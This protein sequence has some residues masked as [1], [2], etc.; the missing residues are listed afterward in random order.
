MNPKT[1]EDTP[2]YLKEMVVNLSQYEILPEHIEFIP[3]TTAKPPIK[4]IAS[5]PI[6]E[7]DYSFC[8]KCNTSPNGRYHT[9]QLTIELYEG[10]QDYQLASVFADMFGDGTPSI[11]KRKE[12]NVPL[13]AHF[14]QVFEEAK[15]NDMFK[16]N[17]TYLAM[18]DF[19]LSYV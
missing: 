3:D 16:S 12:L 1:I 18:L 6:S 11:S 4:A 9:L 5:F 8:L 14:K 13:F 2:E 10:M 15:T 7:E 19:L 17:K